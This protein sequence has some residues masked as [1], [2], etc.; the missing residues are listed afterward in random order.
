MEL[1][2]NDLGDPWPFTDAL[3]AR[4]E[5]LIG[6]TREAWREVPM[7][8]FTLAHHHGFGVALQSETMARRKRVMEGPVWI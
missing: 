3:G 1:S 6:A 5:R 8:A 2:S 7:L 4:F